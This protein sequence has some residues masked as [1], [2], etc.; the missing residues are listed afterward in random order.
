VNTEGWLPAFA[1]MTIVLSACGG[2][3][4]ADPVGPVE[5]TCQQDPSQ[6]KCVSTQPTTTLR[7]LATTKGK[8]VGTALDA[9]FFGANPAQYDT[10]VAREFSVVVAGNVMKWSSIHRDAR[11]AYRWTNPDALVAF[12]QA[13]GMKV[14]GHTLFWHN[15]NPT[16]LTGATWSADTL[17]VLMKEHVDSVVG[18]YKGKIHAWDVVNEALND[19]SGTLRTTNSPWATAL[20]REYIDIAFREARAVDPGALLFYNDYNLE[21][22]GAKQDS[23]FALVQGMKA[24]GVPIDGVGFQAHFQ[25]NADG[26]GV[27][28]RQTM[29]AT[30]ERFAALGLKVELTELDI[31]VRTPGASAAELAAQAQGYNDVVSACVAV[32]ACDA[33]V[34]WGVNDGES[35]VNTTFPGYGQAL[36][37]D[38]SFGRKATYN[39]VKAALGG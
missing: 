28:S 36:L 22:P 19:G 23:A 38:D 5:K 16:W 2:G 26:S 6:A 12:A 35:W 18:H 4:G 11:Y 25:V 1:G 13:N 29:I 32:A 8:Y 24:R 7:Q 34:V 27:P 10:L 37:F 30:L 17:K 20:G 39:A 3:G 33:I 14:R 15:Q 31:R 9:A 21:F